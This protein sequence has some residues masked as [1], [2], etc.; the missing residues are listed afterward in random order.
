MR[1]QDA[2]DFSA[3]HLLVLQEAEQSKKAEL[4]RAID[5]LTKRQRE[6]VYLKFFQG[7]TNHATAEVMGLSEASVNTLVSQSVKALRQA[8]K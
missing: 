5:G 3:E 6:S 1:L 8:L 4:R 7:L 2:I